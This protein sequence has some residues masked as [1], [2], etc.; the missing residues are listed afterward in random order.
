M[1]TLLCTATRCNAP[2]SARDHHMTQRSPKPARTEESVFETID[3]VTA[4]ADAQTY[5]DHLR[6]LSVLPPGYGR[7]FAFNSVN[8]DL[9]NGGID[10]LR[11]N[12]TWQLVPTAIAACRSAGTESLERLLREIVLYYHER[13]RSKLAR[14]LTDDYFAGIDRPLTKSI[15]TMQTE[16]FRNKER[17]TVVSRLVALHDKELW[18]DE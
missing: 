15:A 2:S 5:M 11:K 17:E 12:S 14:Q 1:C 4:K 6:A 10:Q 8:A 16:Y 18:N 9:C 7:C 3:E 13:G